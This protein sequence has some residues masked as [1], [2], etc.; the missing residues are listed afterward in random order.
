MTMQE[1]LNQRATYE[2]RFKDFMEHALLLLV[3]QEGGQMVLDAPPL[4]SELESE[5]MQFEQKQPLA[6]TK[7]PYEMAQSVQTAVSTYLGES[8][9]GDINDMR[10]PGGRH[11]ILVKTDALYRYG[12]ERVFRTVHFGEVQSAIQAGKDVPQENIEFHGDELTVMDRET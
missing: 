3:R 6:Q 4:L 2:T 8:F 12:P 10:L 9:P 1:K 11:I 7:S 5:F